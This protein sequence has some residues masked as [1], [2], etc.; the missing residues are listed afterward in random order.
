MSPRTDIIVQNN[1]IDN[2]ED[3]KIDIESKQ[4]NDLLKIYEIAMIQVTDTMNGIK[5]R[6]NNMYGYTIIEK[7]DSRLKSK[8]SILNK[9]KKK[10]IALTYK[11]LVDNV[12]DIAG[13]RIVC[14]LKDDIFLI[15]QIIENMP[16][17]KIIQEKDY[18]CNPKKSGYSAYH[19]IV[20]TPVTINSETVII[21]VEIQIRTVAMDFW[22]EMEHDIRYK[23]NN[24]VSKFDSKK[25]TW[26]AKALE[27][28]Q[29]KIIKL[30]RKQENNSMF[31]Y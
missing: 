17:L 27:N 15:K 24:Q 3:E 19:L 7:V 31:N 6:I 21:K 20:E 23:T 28:L 10:N 30:Y 16:N 2:T 12:D 25:L 11:A 1:K 22:S 8:K 26:Y 29:A 14:P 13:V 5:A 4:Y 18:I 9:L